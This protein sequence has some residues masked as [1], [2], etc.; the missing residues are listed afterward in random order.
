VTASTGLRGITAVRLEVLADPRLPKQGPGLASADGNFVL[1]EFEVYVQAKGSK[2]LPQK[3]T[4]TQ[5]LADFSQQN[6]DVKFAVD[7]DAGSRDRGW[8]VS[9][10]T[11]VSHWATF[12]IKEP[13][14]L[15]SGATLTFKLINQFQQ[16][17]YGVGRFRLALA[18]QKE[19]VGLSLS[20]EFRA[21]QIT[22]AAQRTKEQQEAVLKYIRKTD[23]E[24]RNRQKAVADSRAPLPI[25]PRLKELRD[26]LEYFS[27]PV[28]EDAIL[29][30]LRQDVEQ[31]TKQVANPRLTGAQDITW[32]LINSPA[33][34]FNH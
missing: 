6:F 16:P 25:D 18:T 2:D 3:L 33:F 30:Q 17:G 29:V 34:L 15:A 4:L 27:R 31:S 13:I 12:Q 32:A 26:T 24:L 28:P 14:D 21:I 20:D 11:G 7:G 22:P 10:T 1:T 5:P 9:P 23:E 8:A 19:P